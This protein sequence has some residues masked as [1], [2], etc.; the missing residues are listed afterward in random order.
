VAE[1]ARQLTP[2]LEVAHL[3]GAGHNIRRERSDAFVHTVRDVLARQRLPSDP[4]ATAAG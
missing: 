4:S 2:N 3:A 1:Q